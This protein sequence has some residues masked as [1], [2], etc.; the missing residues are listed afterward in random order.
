LYTAR[1]LSSPRE[2]QAILAAL[3]RGPAALVTLVAVAGSSYRRPG[4]R[5]LLLPDGRSIGSISGGCLEEDLRERARA[6]LAG[7][8]P[9]LVTYD[10][11]DENDLV[12]GTGLGCRG[13]VRVFI[14]RLPDPLPAWVGA[15]RD[16]FRERRDTALAVAFGAGAE[17]GTRLAA[18]HGDGTD[19]ETFVEHVD[20]PPALL[21]FGAGD[22]AQPLAALGGLL[23][24]E[25]SVFDTRP[26]YAT[27]ER[28]P[29]ARRVIAGPADAAARHESVRPDSQAIVM[30]HRYRDDLAVLRVLLTTPLAYLGVLGP[31]HRTE[32]LLRELAEAGVAPDAAARE[33]LF[34]PVGLDLGGASPETVAL[35]IV[36]ELQ[37]VRSKRRPAH[38]RDVARPIHG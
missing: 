36:A 19:T 10:T 1:L 34:T 38:L 25:V 2:I 22:D 24:W 5:L 26:A 20:P 12:W 13:E 37:A 15:L 35:S 16:N 31:R 18:D 28:F 3:E 30:S 27:A 32:R 9:Q 21:L 33:R 6:V 7:G 4:A 29:G 8:A 17:Q 11:S 23:G 14:E